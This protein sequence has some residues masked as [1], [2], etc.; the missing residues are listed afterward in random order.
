MQLTHYFNTSHFTSIDNDT[1]KSIDATLAELKDS[2]TAKRVKGKM[3]EAQNNPPLFIQMNM[4]KLA[5]ALEPVKDAMIEAGYGFDITS[6]YRC[7]E[8]NA[9]VGGKPNSAHT[10]GLAADIR[11]TSV[12][13]AKAIIQALIAAG[14]RRIGLGRSFIH[15]DLS[16]TLPSPACWVY[17]NKNKTPRWLQ[18]MEPAIDKQLL[19]LT[20]N[21]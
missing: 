12:E 21:K 4:A 1:D 5:G 18:A 9:A 17:S 8:L 20:T 15:A 16:K 10:V 3:L 13:H 19:Q 2:D 6:G 14:F 11:F 7:V